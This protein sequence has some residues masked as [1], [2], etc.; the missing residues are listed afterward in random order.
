MGL[1]QQNNHDGRCEHNNVPTFIPLPSSRHVRFLHNA[2]N[3]R[4]GRLLVISASVYYV[5]VIST[6]MFCETQPRIQR[7]KRAKLQSAIL[8]LSKSVM[9][10]QVISAKISTF[11]ASLQ[12]TLTVRAQN[13]HL[14]SYTA[15]SGNLL[16]SG[17]SAACLT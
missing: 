1:I 9:S 4:Y 11:S 10:F 8:I 6:K 3:Q 17:T 16:H 7:P 15:C 14:T 12:S 5:L 2:L 13:S